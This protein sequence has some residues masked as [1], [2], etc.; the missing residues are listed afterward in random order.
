MAGYNAG[1]EANAT[2]SNTNAGLYNVPV[3]ATVPIGWSSSATSTAS[4][5]WASGPLFNFTFKSFAGQSSGSIIVYVILGLVGIVV[6][7]KIIS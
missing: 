3:N 4:G 6:I 5:G 2:Q 1:Q 7:R